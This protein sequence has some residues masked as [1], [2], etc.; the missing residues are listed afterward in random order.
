[1]MKHLFWYPWVMAALVIGIL[2]CLG[3][4]ARMLFAQAPQAAYVPNAQLVMEG[5]HH[6]LA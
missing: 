1:M 5:F 2:I 6:A 4:I 3:L